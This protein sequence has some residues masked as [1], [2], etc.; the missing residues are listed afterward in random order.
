MERLFLQPFRAVESDNPADNYAT[1]FIL[2][3]DATRRTGGYDQFGSNFQDDPVPHIGI[4]K[5]SVSAW[6][7]RV[8]VLR[9]MRFRFEYDCLVRSN[10]CGPIRSEKF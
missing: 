3:T 9:Q 2:L 4:G 5:A 7:F 8:V 6:W 1:Y 10:C